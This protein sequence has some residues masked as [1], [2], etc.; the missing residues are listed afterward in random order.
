MRISIDAE[1]I[2]FAFSGENQDF[3]DILRPSIIGINNAIIEDYEK[4]LIQEGAGLGKDWLT[5]IY[6]NPD[7]ICIVND[8][9]LNKYGLNAG[10]LCEAYVGAAYFNGH[11]LISHNPPASRT[12]KAN[13]YGVEVI[14]PRLKPNI[15]LMDGHRIITNIQLNSKTSHKHAVVRRFFENE[16]EI[17]IYDKFIKDASMCLFENIFRQCHPNAKI[18]LIS[19]FDSTGKSTITKQDAE[20][21]I[22]AV[23]PHA[24]VHC[25]YPA[26]RGNDDDHDRHIHIGNRLQMSFTRGTD[27]FGL[28]PNWSNSECDISVHYLSEKSAIRS[29]FVSDT[30]RKVGFEIKVRS[31]I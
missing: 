4:K 3:E 25:Y 17:V 1:A 19:E 23:R 21:R 5:R 11:K 10:D 20:R 30:P 6:G 2:S 29:Y 7:R 8:D 24:S 22:K 15:A 14:D 13:R 31:K 26:L 28:H 9:D 12:T 18:V 16:I 27:C